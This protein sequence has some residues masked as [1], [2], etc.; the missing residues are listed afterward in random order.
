MFQG[1]AGPGAKVPRLPV[2]RLKLSPGVAR[3]R[4][5][6]RLPLIAIDARGPSLRGGCAYDKAKPRVEGI[7]LPKVAVPFVPQTTFE[8]AAHVSDYA[9]ND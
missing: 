6:P 7:K 3:V 1:G 2:F 4:S 5:S 9:L 8:I